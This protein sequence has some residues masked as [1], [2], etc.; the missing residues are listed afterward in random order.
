MHTCTCAGQ[1]PAL[2]VLTPSFEKLK[3]ILDIYF[4]YTA[5]LPAH[6]GV[7]HVHAPCLRRS[8]EG[9]R[10]LELE[11]RIVVSYHAAGDQ[12]QVFCQSSQ[13]FNH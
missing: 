7:Y 6:V 2:S 4:T 1:R 9:I 11:V 12:I 13:F 10:P 3:Y 8:K 5:F